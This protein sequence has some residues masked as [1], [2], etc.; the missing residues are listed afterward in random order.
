MVEKFI[1]DD[2]FF[3][4]VRLKAYIVVHPGMALLQPSWMVLLGTNEILG[5]DLLQIYEV[6]RLFQIPS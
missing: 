5:F 3:L 2:M 4:A 6:L 1:Q